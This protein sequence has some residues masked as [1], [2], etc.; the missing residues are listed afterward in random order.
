M[1]VSSVQALLARTATALE[2]GH[3]ADAAHMLAPI[4]RST[5]PRDD[6]L[7][8]RAMLAEAWLQQD[9][10]E[11]AAAALGR[12]PD[13][14]RDT[15]APVRLATYCQ[16]TGSPCTTWLATSNGARFGST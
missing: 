4:L 8:I 13:T 14:F 2:R 9:D 7:S 3:G 5:L 11:Q 16:G 12:P 10:L 15:I 6:E 1:L